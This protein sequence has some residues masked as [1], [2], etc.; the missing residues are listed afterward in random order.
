MR[1]RGVIGRIRWWHIG[2]IILLLIGIYLAST[3]TIIGTKCQ[4]YCTA[5]AQA[6]LDAK[7]VCESGV[8]STDQP[9]QYGVKCEIANG[10]I[11]CVECRRNYCTLP[12]PCE[13]GQ[14]HYTCINECTGVIDERQYACEETCKFPYTK[15]DDG[16]C[17]L[18]CIGSDNECNADS[19]CNDNIAST[20]DRCILGGSA[21]D[22]HYVCQNIAIPYYEEKIAC[23]TKVYFGLQGY[24]WVANPTEQC[25]FHIDVPLI[26]SPI[27]LGC[28]TVD[29]P[30]CRLKSDM[31]LATAVVSIL[32]LVGLGLVVKKQFKRR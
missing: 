32:V 10:C 17:K 13:N 15:C 6:L 2:L 12:G 19:D 9:T 4:G 28:K 5:D 18:L 25:W 31:I 30:Y 27:N 8:G 24:E 29:Q 23:Q 1:L 7:T 16:S 20:E 22:R 26:G 3:L 14:K 11:S 21:L